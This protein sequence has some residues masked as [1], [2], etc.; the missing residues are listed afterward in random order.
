M[1]QTS[2]Q[3]P[4]G[5]MGRR[6]DVEGLV[7][8]QSRVPG[9]HVSVVLRLRAIGRGEHHYSGLIISEADWSLAA[10]LDGATASPRL[11]PFMHCYA[12]DSCPGALNNSSPLWLRAV[13]L[14]V[15][16]SLAPS[17]RLALSSSAYG[18]NEIVT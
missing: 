4:V 15:G 8:S 17:W 16:P 3:S 10:H 11:R 13:L 12:G 18:V 7:Y 1:P 6:G 2:P 5:N 14:T 9:P